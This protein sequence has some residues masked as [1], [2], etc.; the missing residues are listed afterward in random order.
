[1]K[2][3]EQECKLRNTKGDIDNNDHERVNYQVR[4]NMKMT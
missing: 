4:A 2:I 1:M 3:C